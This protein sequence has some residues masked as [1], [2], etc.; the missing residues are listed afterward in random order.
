MGYMHI[1]NLY[2]D[3][4]I[5][6]HKRCYALEKVHGTSAHVGYNPQDGLHFFSGGVKNEPFRALF[7]HDSLLANLAG[8]QHVTVYGEAYGGSC[9]RMQNTYGP[10]LRFIVF[11]VKADGEWLTVPVAAETV[12][13]LGLEFVPWCETHTDVPSLDALRDAPSEV[14]LR[15]GMGTQV[16][17]GIVLRPLQECV[18]GHGSR[19]IAK[20]KGAAFSERGTPPPVDATKLVVL[21]QATAIAQEWVTPMRLEHVLQKLPGVGIEDMRTVISVMMEDVTREAAGEIVV[22]P[23]ALK[24]IAQR[25]AALFKAHLQA[26][27]GA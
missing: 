24:A 22:T 12:H 15:R 8:S 10:D 14:A 3:Q 20:H 4:T 27:I 26:G 21:E 23:V 9:Q 2:K 25:T 6:Q 11:D 16:R 1:N 17:E 18:D 5:L 19:V 7:D 13:R